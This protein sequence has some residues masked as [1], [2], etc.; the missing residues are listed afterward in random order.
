[1]SSLFPYAKRL[2]KYKNAIMDIVKDTN[3]TLSTYITGQALIALILG[4]L[5]YIGYLIIGFKY[6]FIL[7]FFVVITSFIPMF[8]AVIGV[9]PACF[10]GLSTSIA[11]FLA[12]G[13]LYGFIGMLIAVPTCAAFKVVAAGGIRILKI[14]RSGK[15]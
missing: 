2:V 15:I 8:G 3:K 9:V 11:L 10:V 4:V 13:S 14:W 7:S 5:S 1:M 6:S 12:A